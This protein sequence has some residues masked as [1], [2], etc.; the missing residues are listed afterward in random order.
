MGLYGHLTRNA[1]QLAEDFGVPAD[2][3]RSIA[4]SIGDN[5]SGLE[6]EMAALKRVAIEHGLPA[7]VIESLLHNI[8]NAVPHSRSD[9]SS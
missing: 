2:Q 1:D 4:A 3:L 8:R 6:D 5:G 9:R 7:N